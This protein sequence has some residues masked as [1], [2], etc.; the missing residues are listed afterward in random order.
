MATYL[1]PGA[2]PR[3]PKGVGILPLLGGL[4][5]LWAEA[6]IMFVLMAVAGIYTLGW[7]I[8]RLLEKGGN[9]VRRAAGY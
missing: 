5:A 2:R 9:A 3:R 1:Y 8:R 4:L 7:I 6:T